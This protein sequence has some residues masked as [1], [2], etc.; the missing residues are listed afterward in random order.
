MHSYIRQL[1]IAGGLAA[2]LGL[3]SPARADVIGF[4]G[5]THNSAGSTAIGEAQLTMEI[6]DNGNGDARFEFHNTGPYRASI[7]DIYFELNN[8]AP[9]GGLVGLI[10]RDD[11]VNGE[12]GHRR[13]DFSQGAAPPDLPG[14]SN[15]FDVTPGYAFD[16]DSPTSH[17]GVKRGR[18]LGI[19]FS[20]EDGFDV[21]DIVSSILAGQIRVGL[22]V[23]AFDNGCSESFVSMPPPPCPVPA[24][25]AALLGLMGFGSISTL[26]RRLTSVG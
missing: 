18:W 26:R 7:T 5:I 24:P 17:R 8:G 11:S 20:V 16:S 21:E 22:H 25:G 13:V 1:V 15:D 19:V 2:C 12:Y 4:T 23:Q 9:L 10:D 14:G 3:I 6:T